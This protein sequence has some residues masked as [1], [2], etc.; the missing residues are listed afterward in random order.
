M[1]TLLCSLLSRRGVQVTG[2]L[3]VAK[4]ITADI[5]GAKCYIH[6]IDHVL[7]PNLA[8]AAPTYATIAEAFAAYNLTTILAAVTAVGGDLL[9]IATDPAAAITVLAP[10]D[11][12]SAISAGRLHAEH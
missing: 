9:A 5:R 6:I 10:T 7:I 2:Y 4:V 8:P 11:A 1:L 12:V 3:T